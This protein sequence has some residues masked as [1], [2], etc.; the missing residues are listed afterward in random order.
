MVTVSKGTA[1]TVSQCHL[2]DGCLMMEEVGKW[3]GRVI[4]TQQGVKY[5]TPLSCQLC[6]G[7]KLPSLIVMSSRS[8]FEQLF[9]PLN[10]RGSQLILKGREGASVY[11]LNHFF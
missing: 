4:L 11:F 2:G 3:S 9:T 5:G 10:V 7:E 8:L 6:A 1:V